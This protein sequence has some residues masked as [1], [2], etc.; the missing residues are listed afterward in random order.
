MKSNLL[1]MLLIESQRF[2]TTNGHIKPP[3]THSQ[4]E[5][6]KGCLLYCRVPP[7]ILGNLLLNGA[8]GVLYDADFNCDEDISNDA[9]TV[10][11][12]MMVR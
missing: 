3:Y 4:G 5:E 7:V 8:P 1:L 10:I 2:L 11:M 6:K 9:L 12:M